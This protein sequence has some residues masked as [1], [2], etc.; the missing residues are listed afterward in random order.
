MIERLMDNDGA[1]V[2]I[3]DDN[4]DQDAHHLAAEQANEFDI[5]LDR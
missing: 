1:P 5:D 4:D 3:I 2:E